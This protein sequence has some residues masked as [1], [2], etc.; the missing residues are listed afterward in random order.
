MCCV[1]AQRQQLAECLAPSSGAPEKRSFARRQAAMLVPS[2]SLN[3]VKPTSKK[4]TSSD[5][6]GFEVKEVLGAGSMGTVKRAVRSSD[7]KEVAIKCVI[8]LDAETEQFTREEYDLMRKCS[9]PAIVPAFS[10]HHNSDVVWLCMEYCSGGCVQSYV[11]RSGAFGDES[12]QLLL[13]QFLTG[14][15]HLHCTRV[16]HRDLKPANLVLN[17]EASVLKITDF[18]SAKQIGMAAGPGSGSLMLTDRG[19]RLYCAPEMRFGKIWNERVDVWGYGLCAYLMLRAKLPFNTGDRKVEARWLA[20]QN[21]PIAFGNIPKMM[22]SLVLQCLTIN[23][24]NRPAAFELLVH[25]AFAAK[26]FGQVTA[27]SDKPS[28]PEIVVSSCGLL[29]LCSSQPKTCQLPTTTDA[30]HS[31]LGDLFS[32]TFMGLPLQ[33][34]QSRKQA[35]RHLMGNRLGRTSNE[36]LEEPCTN[37][38]RRKHGTDCGS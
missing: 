37:N 33:E 18:N 38:G 16:V 24:Y 30:V 9:H 25:P 10:F 13:W 29:S 32:S 36:D 20:G 11:E 1:V 4:Q 19:E 31:A 22:Q 6:F 15:D 27:I 28:L 3:T 5:M 8:N 34:R 35:L 21:P 2:L 26:D 23:M 14:L 12:G 17:S 7:R